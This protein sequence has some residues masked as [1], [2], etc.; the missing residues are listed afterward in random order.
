LWFIII[1]IVV[2]VLASYLLRTYSPSGA[3]LPYRKRVPFLSAAERSF[4]RVL[5]GVAAVRYEVFAKVGI[6]E[7]LY[8]PGREEDRQS[9]RNKIQQ[10]RV[11][12]VLCDPQ[13]LQ[14]A[15]VVELDDSS[16]RR[17]D[18]R[19][20]DAF[21]DQAMNC[22]GL[23]I[24]HVPARTSYSPA[25]LATELERVMTGAPAAAVLPAALPAA[26]P[27]ANSRRR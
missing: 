2:A 22:A 18:R 17:P 11:D 1:A 15:V 6:G 4:F 7:L 5:K 27:A 9:Y 3:R 13:T 8:V 23:P 16:H 21:V 10:K 25:E 14:P 20:R 12:F 26:R 19:D 24:L